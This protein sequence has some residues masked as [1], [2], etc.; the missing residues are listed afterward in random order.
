MDKKLVPS[1]STD[2]SKAFYYKMK[3]DYYRYLAEFATGETK[4]KAGEDACVAHAKAT[5]IAEK[6]LVVTHPVRLAMAPSSSKFQSEVLQNPDDVA[7]GMHFGKNDLDDVSVVAQRQIPMV[8]STRA[9]QCIDKMVDNQVMQVPQVAEQDTEVPKTSSRDRTS[10]RSVEQI[11]ETPAISLLGKIVEMPVQTKEKTRQITNPQ[12]QHVVKTVEAEMPNIIKETV[13]RKWPVINEKINQVTKH[14][15]VP[16]V[17]VSEKAVEIP[18]FHI[19]G[20]IDEIPEIWTDVDTQQSSSSQPEFLQLFRKSRKGRPRS[21]TRAQD[22]TAVL[23]ET[24]RL[25]VEATGKDEASMRQQLVSKR[26]VELL[27]DREFWRARVEKKQR[28]QAK[29][30]EAWEFFRR[31]PSFKPKSKRNSKNSGGG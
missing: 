31:V 10:Q 8:Q 9:L 6:N 4:S 18:Q 5:E 21:N 15:E 11:I 20:Q 7:D 14:L 22:N 28:F 2:E 24:Q 12:V 29:K 30:K 26:S 27:R 17:Q 23:E 3:S 16:Q 13:Q 1:P 25:F 19:V